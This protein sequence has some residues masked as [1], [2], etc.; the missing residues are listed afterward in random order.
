VV[1]NFELLINLLSLVGYQATAEA[2]GRW[3]DKDRQKVYEWAGLTHLAAS[4]NDVDVPPRPD[5]LPPPWTG[6]VQ[7]AGTIWETNPTVLA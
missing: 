5:I 1:R 3:D 6:P 4:D 7:N 2:V